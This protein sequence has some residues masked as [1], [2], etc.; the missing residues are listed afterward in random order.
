MVPLDLNGSHAELLSI[1]GLSPDLLAIGVSNHCGFINLGSIRVNSDQEKYDALTLIGC[2]KRDME[3]LRAELKK[4]EEYYVTLAINLLKASMDT[5]AAGIDIMSFSKEK[6]GE[7]ASQ[8]KTMITPS[9]V[10][11]V[12]YT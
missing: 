10:Q 5:K 12:L 2:S 4:K 1:P 7:M 6:A 8:I 11:S 9:M 3:E